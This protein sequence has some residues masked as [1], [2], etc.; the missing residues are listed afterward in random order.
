MI[1]RVSETSLSNRAQTYTVIIQGENPVIENI[2]LHRD[3]LLL[4]GRQL[5][6]HSKL[7][8]NQYH[9]STH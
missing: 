3:V 1:E 7:Q 8:L 2:L 9:M 6:Q 5:Q 4:L